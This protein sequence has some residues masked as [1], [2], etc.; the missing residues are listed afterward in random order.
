MS[1]FSPSP[2][3]DRMLA[4]LRIV[5]GVL[6]ISFGTMKLFGFPPMP[7]GTPAVHLL[8]QMGVGGL[9]ETI[10]GTLVVLGLLV[11][12]VTFVLA[13]EMAVAYWQFHA[14]SSPFPTSNM[15]IPAILYCFL[16]LYLCFAG[17]GAWS[18]DRRI[19][20]ARGEDGADARRSPAV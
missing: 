3:A 14:P 9:L 1:I 15:G 16:Y 6:F 10:G 18:L 19:A 13:G 7:P 4:V 2:Y 8:S 11:R 12:P 20:R 5:A 17:G